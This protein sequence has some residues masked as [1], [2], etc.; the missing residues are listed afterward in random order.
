MRLRFWALRESGLAERSPAFADYYVRFIGHFVNVYE[1]TAPVFAR[2]SWR[3][4]ADPQNI[5]TY[6][7]DGRIMK[8]VLGLTVEEAEVQI[9]DSEANDFVWP[10]H[11]YDPSSEAQ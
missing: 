4:S 8:D 7:D 2:E 3:W 11:Q 1:S 9:P 10:Y 6:L 5:Q